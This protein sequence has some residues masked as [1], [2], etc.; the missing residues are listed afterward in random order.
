[1]LKTNSTKAV[2]YKRTIREIESKF[3]VLRADAFAKNNALIKG[4]KVKAVD[5]VY[6]LFG[7]VACQTGVLMAASLLLKDLFAKKKKGAD[8]RQKVAQRLAK[9]TLTDWTKFIYCFRDTYLNQLEANSWPRFQ[10]LFVRVLL[11]EIQV[12]QES[13]ERSP[14]AEM[15]IIRSLEHI[16]AL[17]FTSQQISRPEAVKLIKQATKEISAIFKEIGVPVL[18]NDDMNH[19]IR[20]EVAKHVDGWESDFEEDADLDSDPKPKGNDKDM[21]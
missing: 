3:K 20:R 14:D 4:D 1:M 17:S 2:N 5:E 8:A 19:H 18:S 7:T 11:P 16:R 15:I 6:R 21:I 12:F 9:L 13:P 10:K